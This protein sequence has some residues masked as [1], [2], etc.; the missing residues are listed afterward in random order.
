M[1]LRY[2]TSCALALFVLGGC[3]KKVGGQVVAVVN[4]QE[5]TRQEL[6]AE[7]GNAN[8]PAGADRDRVMNQVLQQVIDRKLLIAKA[9]EQG[10][11][12]SPAYLAQVQRAQDAAL[13]QMLAGNL[14]KSIK[15]PDSAATESFIASTPTL[16][17]ERKRYQLD[18]IVFTAGNDP[19]L[20]T[21]LKPAKTM[22][23]VEAVLKA[24]GIEYQRA[25]G[26]LDTATVPPPIAARIAA[27]PPGEPFLVPQNG[28]VIASVISST[29]AAPVS[30]AQAQP[31]AVELLRRQAVDQALRKQVEQARAAAKIEYQPG[32]SAPKP[33]AAAPKPS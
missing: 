25:K 13:V 21:K 24:A 1:K 19:A 5:I 15:V 33:A 22:A 10:L 29:E 6:N 11:D 32:F 3:D 26:Q 16:F 2:L 20:A 28:R 18:Q 17:G 12:K 8:L 23:E 7:L 27:L 14:A 31:V 30:G 9:K 4:G